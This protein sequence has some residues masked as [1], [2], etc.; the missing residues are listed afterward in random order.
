M[1]KDTDLSKGFFS[2]IEN[3]NIDATISLDTLFF[4]T[5]KYNFDNRK[6]FKR[7]PYNFIQNKISL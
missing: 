7:L 3:L 1:A 5:Q 6:F 4:T 2:K